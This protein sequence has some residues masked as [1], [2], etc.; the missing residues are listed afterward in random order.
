MKELMSPEDWSDPIDDEFKRRSLRYP[1]R[2]PR[3][4]LDGATALING[5][6][7]LPYPRIVIVGSNGKSSTAFLAERL[8]REAGLKT[9]LYTSPHVARWTER[10]LVDGQQVES[11]ELADA[12]SALDGS[13]TDDRIEHDA[14]RFFDVLTAAAAAIFARHRVDVA[15]FEAGI[16]GKLDATRCLR[17]KV[18]CLTG[19]SLEHTQMLGETR[20]EIMTDKLCVAPPGGH[21][22]ARIPAELAPLAK[23]L[24]IERG[25]DLDLVETPPHVAKNYV[26]A[27]EW[28]ARQLI[29]T[30]ESVGLIQLPVPLEGVSIE[31][32]LT[33][34]M[35][36]GEV[37]GVSFVADV[38][39]NQDAWN[40][41]LS[42]VVSMG[43]D[44]AVGVVALTAERP[45][46]AL[47]AS[48]NRFQWEQVLVTESSY[49]AC[50]PAKE[51]AA[52]LSASDIPANEVLPDS[53]AFDRALEVAKL[54]DATLL[55]FGSHYL[56]NDFL[57]WLA[58]KS[59][60]PT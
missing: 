54:T 42:E 35:Q 10:V 52:L 60:R 55:V 28:L 24:A 2:V 34:R 1:A 16:G 18:S 7:E 39:H 46:E 17:P 20:E 29:K 43:I 44:N 8:L 32:S 57:R 49:S 51:I 25:F 5:L 45:A 40:N 27:N 47:P 38:A 58:F 33:G 13:M 15:V 19:I 21:V 14:L 31:T 30:A 6:G 37:D 3:S 48:L 12:V 9:G 59:Y 50:H 11:G 23:T 56:T 41:F 53:T 22:V 26:L 36:A 4:N